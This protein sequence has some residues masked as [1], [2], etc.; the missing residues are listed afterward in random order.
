MKVGQSLDNAFKNTFGKMILNY[1]KVYAP[2]NEN[3]GE[4]FGYAGSLEKGCD[5][6]CAV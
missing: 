1:G 4:L 2:V 5:Q 3:F 6:E